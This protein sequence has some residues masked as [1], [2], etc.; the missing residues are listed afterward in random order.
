MAYS[1]QYYKNWLNNKRWEIES[2]RKKNEQLS[3]DIARLQR[4]Y[5]KLKKIKNDSNVDAERVKGQVKLDKI[6][7]DAKWR[8]KS[9]NNFDNVIKDDA[10]VAAKDFY[11]SIDKMLDQ[12][13]SE[14]SR[15]KGSYDTGIG[16]LNGM[17][18][19]KNWLEGV[20]RN[21]TN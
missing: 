18:K 19:T 8:G 16:A 9:K 3:K 11:K 10:K 1:L 2:R 4:A 17:I 6:A 12:V 5:D 21:W 15:K 7:P 20:I 13:G 14:L